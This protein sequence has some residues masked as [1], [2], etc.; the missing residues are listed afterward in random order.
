MVFD[1]KLMSL[2]MAQARALI[3]GAT[4]HQG[5][6][7]RLHRALMSEYIKDGAK[8]NINPIKQ[9]AQD[10]VGAVTNGS[11]YDV[12][13]RNGEFQ[14]REQNLFLAALNFLSFLDCSSAASEAADDCLVA[15]SVSSP[16]QSQRQ[17]SLAQQALA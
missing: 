10:A 8:Q 16:T 11:D 5:D 17:Q 12:L 7:F 13:L 4:L 9:V 14:R 6:Q 15:D 3:A 2:L 1:V